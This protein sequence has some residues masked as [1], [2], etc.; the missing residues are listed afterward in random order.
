KVTSEA[1]PADGSSHGT[2]PR[3]RGLVLE[4]NGVRHPLSPPG[5]VIGRGSDADLRIDDPGV[6]RRHAM[7]SVS[8]TLDDPQV[9]IEDLGSTNGVIVNG[10]RVQST[11]VADGAR[12]E[13][14]NT[15][16]LVHSPT[17]L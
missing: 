3:R 15:R 9:V 11:S 16:M 6:S 14:G 5:M 4:V 7:L 12:I 1:T 8:G 13:L 10:Q 17:E 2:R